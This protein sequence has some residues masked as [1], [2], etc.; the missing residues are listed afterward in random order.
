M[1][2]VFTFIVAVLTMSSL[3]AI[4]L[5]GKQ[6]QGSLLRGQ[7]PAG[8]QVWLDE[9]EIKVAESGDFALG[10]S[11]DDKLNWQLSWQLPDGAKHSKE[12]VLAKRIYKEEH[13]EGLPPKM[14]TPPE[15]TLAR[16]RQDS[17]MV[18]EA[19]SRFEVDNAFAQSF[20]W[21]TTGRIS[22]V[23]GSRRVLNGEPKRPHYGIDIAAPEGHPVYAPAAGLVT[24][25]VPDMYY[26]GG[27]M[28]I[29][30]GFGVSSTFLHLST[31]H[32]KPGQRVEQGDLIAEVGSTG[33][34][35]GPHLDW[36]MNWFEKRVDPQ[37]LVPSEPQA[38]ST[39]AGE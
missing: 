5:Q 15:S 8:T 29:D 19:R 6:V 38:I 34:S 20:I 14:V 35:T 16:I 3:E 39:K 2:R 22:G 13:I 33:R 11:R 31:S 26:S 4:E 9:R 17:K 12:M 10:F 25:Y 30:H 7:V 18:R 28:I 24:L 1:L 36:R 21:P 27:T 32:V 37:L 23:Y